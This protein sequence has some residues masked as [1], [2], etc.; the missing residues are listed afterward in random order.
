M[1]TKPT[2]RELAYLIARRFS[3]QPNTS[4]KT[5]TATSINVSAM[6][7]MMAANSAACLLPFANSEKGNRIF[8]LSIRQN[9]H[10]LHLKKIVLI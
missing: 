4:V 10:H 8:I 3:I 7:W 1:N 9:S 6:K 2:T 5:A